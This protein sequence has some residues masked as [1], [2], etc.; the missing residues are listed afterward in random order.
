MARVGVEENGKE[1]CGAILERGKV[2][3][4]GAMNP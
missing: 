1:G 4:Q 3:G 2:G